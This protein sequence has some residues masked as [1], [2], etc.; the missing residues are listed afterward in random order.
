[1]VN[2]YSCDVLYVATG[3]EEAP[4]FEVNRDISHLGRCEVF[5]VLL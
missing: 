4:G 1:M 2:V 5:T 3:G